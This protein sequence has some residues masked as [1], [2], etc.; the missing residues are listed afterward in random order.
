MLTYSETND[1]RLESTKSHLA[2]HHWLFLQYHRIRTYSKPD[3]EKSYMTGED[4]QNQWKY[5]SFPAWINN[6][7]NKKGTGHPPS[8]G[9]TF[10]SQ[11]RR[12]QILLCVDAVQHKVYTNMRQ[13]VIAT[14]RS[15]DKTK[16]FHALG[17]FLIWGCCLEYHLRHL[18]GYHSPNH[19]IHKK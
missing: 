2:L 10:S 16:V 9:H 8:R 14:T 11:C 13:Q 19:S 1:I 15:V 6:K 4:W 12:F 18:W 7:I 17:L 3:D 5:H